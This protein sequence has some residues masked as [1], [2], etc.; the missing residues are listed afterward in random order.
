MSL[1]PLGQFFALGEE[2][3]V[4]GFSTAWWWGQCLQPELFKGQ[5]YTKYTTENEDT[6][7]D[8]EDER[9]HIICILSKRLLKATL[10][11]K[12]TQKI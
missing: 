12:N 1:L 4:F 2:V 3:A 7:N 8:S 11:K 9:I 6:K 5:P 10:F